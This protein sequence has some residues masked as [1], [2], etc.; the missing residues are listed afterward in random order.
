LPDN[1]TTVPLPE[2]P[3]VQGFDNIGLFKRAV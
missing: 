2:K 1:L 3:A